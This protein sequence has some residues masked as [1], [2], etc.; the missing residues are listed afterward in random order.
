M[1]A[2]C[3]MKPVNGLL[4]HEKGWRDVQEMVGQHPLWRVVKGR[5]RG[6]VRRVD[7]YGRP[8]MK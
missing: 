5:S 1:R 3:I 2:F 4:T 8:S 7:K 6:Y